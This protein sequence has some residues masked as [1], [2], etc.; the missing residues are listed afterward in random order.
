M[1]TYT[2]SL[3]VLA[4][5]RSFVELI[6][7]KQTLLLLATL[8]LSYM[9]AGGIDYTR[10]AWASAAAALMIAG[11]TAI[12]MV[13][14]SDIDRLMERTRGRPIPSGRI[15][16][17]EATIY[18][19]TL[20]VVGAILAYTVSPLYLFIGAVGA[21][22]DLAVY[23]VL[24]K[25]RTWLSIFLGAVAGA[26]PAVGGW[27]AA[28][29]AIEPPALMLGGMVAAWIPM[30]IWFLAAYYADD[31][32]RAKI[33]MA[34]NTLGPRKTFRLVQA[35]LAA[36]TILAWLYTLATGRAYTAATAAT[37]LSALGIAL[38]QKYIETLD[39][40]IAWK[41]FKSANTILAITFLLAGLSG[42]NLVP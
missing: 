40:N 31:Y 18:G 32:A 34:P 12:N 42:Y 6:K 27:A 11:T 8:V 17:I 22:F 26:A 14:D 30:H 24:A 21:F 33:P 3:A 29:G 19:L 41:A 15:G 39:R 23:T 13:F 5:A 10:L 20:L 38:A 25:R 36:Y 1:A 35:S 2:V 9:A 4:K 16:P 28:R 7:P 37:I